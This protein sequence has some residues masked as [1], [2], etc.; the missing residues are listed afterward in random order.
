[1]S[2]LDDTSDTDR[3]DDLRASQDEDDEGLEGEGVDLSFREE[4]LHL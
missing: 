4:D 3:L 1:V 2:G